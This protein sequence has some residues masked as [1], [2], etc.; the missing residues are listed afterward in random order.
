M[1]AVADLLVIPEPEFDSEC[2]S[3]KH[4]LAERLK[5][6]MNCQGPNDI[7]YKAD[8]MWFEVVGIT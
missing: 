5:G 6:G 4:E 2:Y 8:R 1:R 7:W 3:N